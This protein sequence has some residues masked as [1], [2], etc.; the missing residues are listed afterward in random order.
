MLSNMNSS[1][2]NKFKRFV[3]LIIP[4]INYYFMHETGHLNQIINYTTTNL[5][6]IRHN[7]SYKQ[8]NW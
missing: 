1:L 6:L 3:L 5:K 2:F 4:K 8:I 7:L